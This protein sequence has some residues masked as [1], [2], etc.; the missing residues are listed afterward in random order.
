MDKHI[1]REMVNRIWYKGFRVYYCFVD[2]KSPVYH[3]DKKHMYCYHD[4][5]QQ[6]LYYRN[7]PIFTKLAYR[8]YS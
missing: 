5:T 6:D 8:I 7:D 3:M 2:W 1:T 4:K